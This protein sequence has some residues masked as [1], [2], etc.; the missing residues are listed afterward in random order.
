MVKQLCV[1]KAIFC[2]LS[3][4]I[5]ISLFILSVAMGRVY[6]QTNA[7]QTLVDTNAQIAAL[8]LQ[9]TNAWHSVEAIV[10]QPARAYRRD[11]SYRISIY[12]PGWFHPGASTPDFNNVDVRKSQELPYTSPWVSSDITPT[13]MF[14]GSDLE[15]NSMTKLFYTNRDLPKKR[16]TEAEM[17]Q[18]NSLY[19]TIGQCKREIEKLQLPSEVEATAADTESDS[20]DTNAPPK[21]I[22]AIERIPQQ[23]RILYGSIGIGVLLVLGIVFRLIR[24]RS[25]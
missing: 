3:G 20:N 18:I 9:L 16:L 25:D 19:R 24:K 1:M 5:C 14:R 12:S 10:N 21:A 13:M 11:D 15:F 7:D 22:A 17:V 23:T 6:A 4:C 2:G 8:Q